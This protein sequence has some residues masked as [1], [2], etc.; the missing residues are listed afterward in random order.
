MKPIHHFYLSFLWIQIH[1]TVMVMVCAWVR[2][3]LCEIEQMKMLLSDLPEKMSR[4]IDTDW[5][6]GTVF[7]LFF[8]SRKK[9]LSSILITW[10]GFVDGNAVT[11]A[12]LTLITCMTH[13]RLSFI[14]IHFV[15]LAAV[16]SYDG[17][18][19]SLFYYNFILRQ[20]RKLFVIIIILIDDISVKWVFMRL[21]A[22]PRE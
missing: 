13:D 21:T 2:L 5:I 15:W 22:T 1:I 19:E 20:Q 18:D 17:R 8:F 4:L 7:F 6:N 14:R 9:N 12:C 10:N 16:R 3:C 11:R